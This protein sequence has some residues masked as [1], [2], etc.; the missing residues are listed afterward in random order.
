LEDFAIVRSAAAAKCLVH[1]LRRKLIAELKQ[2][3]SAASIA[4]RLGMAR[5]VVN[6]HCKA[7]EKAGLVVHV[8]D[9][10]AG[11]CVERV[12]QAVAGEF[13]IAPSVYGRTRAGEVAQD[14][15]SARSAIAS[16]LQTIDELASGLENAAQRNEPFPT[17]NLETEISLASAEQQM[18]FVEEATAALREIARKYNGPGARRAF[19]VKLQSY[20]KAA[21]R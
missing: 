16:S 5:Q 11:N 15:F 1:P 7:L 9:V 21:G 3:A 6:Y 14:R 13:I 18:R 17:L 4:R 8:T 10:K 20:P 2:P 12:L 19:R